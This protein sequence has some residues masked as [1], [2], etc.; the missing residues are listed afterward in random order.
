MRNF[1]NEFCA[2]AAIP[3]MLLV[4]GCADNKDKTSDEI[5]K[6]YIEA[7]MKVNYPGITPTGKGIYILDD[8]EG[9]GEALGDKDYF[10]MIEYTVADMDGTISATTN[11][12][13]AQQI[14]T[15]KKSY[16]YGPHTY[17]RD[18][19]AKPVGVQEILNG[20]KVGGVRT[21]LVPSWLNVARSYSDSTRASNA[22]YTITLADKTDDIRQWEIDTLERYTQKYMKDVDSSFTGYYYL[23]LKAPSDTNT[24]P[25][26]TSFYINYTG[27]L[28]NGLVF[29]TTIE[30]TAKFYGIYSSSK[31]YGPVKIQLSENYT[32]I[33]LE[34]SSSSS[35]SSISSSSEVTGFAYC[36]SQLKRYEKGVCAFMSQY[37]YQYNGNGNSIPSYAPLVFEIEMVDEPK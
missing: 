17:L 1:M 12:K 22:I 21:A 4:S 25:R 27:K 35:S 33:T 5:N 11:P 20:M 36:L 14:G 9:T 30:D 28:L 31:K 26:D 13:I 32:E 34:S 19:L 16:Y 23:Q 18:A 8:K 10:A 3:A 6:E 24:L 2:F 37:G 29:D 7:W 15:Y